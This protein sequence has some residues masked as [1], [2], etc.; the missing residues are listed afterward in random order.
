M[1]LNDFCEIGVYTSSLDS[2]YIA[3]R[4]KFL[5][6]FVQN[7]D[8]PIFH[9]SSLFEILKSLDKQGVINNA[10]MM[11]GNILVMLPVIIV[12]FSCRENSCR[13]SSGPG[14]WNELYNI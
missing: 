13:E 5:V 3:G 2:C 4:L 12:L 7:P 6:A 9:T 14:W 11:A 1:A 10:V 8:N